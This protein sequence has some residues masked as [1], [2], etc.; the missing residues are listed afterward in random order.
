MAKNKK[1]KSSSIPFGGHLLGTKKQKNG[2]QGLEGVFSQGKVWGDLSGWGGSSHAGA[3]GGYHKCYEDHP[4]VKFPHEGSGVLVGGSC[5]YPT[6]EDADVYIGFSSSGMWQTSR[7]YPWTTGN[8]FLF[9]I[10][11]GQAPVDAAA[12]S[13]LVDWTIRE[14]LDGRKVHA[15]CIGGHGRTGMFIVAVV[16]RM[17]PEIEDAIAYVRE[18]YC[19]KAVESVEQVMFLVKNF[20]VKK[21]KASKTGY[22]E[23]KKTKDSMLT[24]TSSS[25]DDL[26]TGPP[27]YGP[28]NVWGR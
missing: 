10:T 6:V 7:A 12:F 28:G 20:G 16:S 18:S 14:L 13:D 9:E 1:P 27:I 21:G 8:E 24:I 4:E 25:H 22:G 19:A 15:G 23:P 17:V 11:D 5:T 26:D 3:G 2:G